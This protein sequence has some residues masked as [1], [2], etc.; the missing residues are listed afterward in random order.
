MAV[1]L[2]GEHTGR[3]RG[4]IRSRSRLPTEARIAIIAIYGQIGAGNAELF[5][6]E[7]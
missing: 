5:T 2:E 3:D 1:A 4:P 6:R 7:G